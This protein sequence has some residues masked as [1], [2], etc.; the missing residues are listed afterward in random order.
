MKSPLAQRGSRAFTLVEL[1]TVIAIISILAA[2]LLPALSRSQLRAKRIVCG[3]NLEQI[4]LAFHT[5]ANDHKGK[6]PM[7]VSTNDGGSMEFVRNGYDA[8]GVFY[9]AF[10]H[11]QALSSELST[12]QIL[13]CP[14]DARLPAANFARLQNENV[15]Y[16]VGVEAD[17]GK[18]GS[19]L[20][21]DRNLAANPPLNPTLLQI[22]GGSRLRW[23]A[24]L[25]QFKGNVLFADGH[26]EEWNN[27]ALV[28]AANNPSSAANLF[29][30]SVP[31]GANM[32]AGG[33]AGSG[34]GAGIS[35]A[36]SAGNNWSANSN[37]ISSASSNAGTQLVA[38]LPA[39]GQSNRPPGMAY[40]GS[41]PF[42]KNQTAPTGPES[43]SAANQSSVPIPSSAS[44][45]GAAAPDDTDLMMSPFNRRIARFLQHLIEWSYLLLLLLLLL[46]LAYKLWRWWQ[47]RR[48]QMQMAELKRMAQETNLDSDESIR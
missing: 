30:P 34:S 26:V 33:M 28:S 44:S 23:T 14:V 15:S 9:S 46:Y 1:L 16:F 22:S 11:F 7:G 19:L 5:F 35:P 48:E 37:R 10:R 38:T 4:G 32:P 31:S 36:A 27:S 21:G 12:P 39:K 6:F 41:R 45:G 20:A 47:K 43:P 42:Y 8:N 40:G 17:F 13:I 29:L 24:E 18:P 25:H 2:L 3:N